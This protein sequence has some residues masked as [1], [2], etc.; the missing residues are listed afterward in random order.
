MKDY[1]RLFN[2][3]PRNSEQWKLKFNARTSAERCNKRKQIDYKLEDDR[4][5]SSMM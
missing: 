3:P 4:Y 2:N 1:P 5:C